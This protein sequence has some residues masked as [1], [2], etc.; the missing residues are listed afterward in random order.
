MCGAVPIY[1]G[2]GHQYAPHPDTHSSTHSALFSLS[3][4]VRP[5]SMFLSSPHDS[6]SRRVTGPRVSVT[7]AS[8]A[9][10]QDEERLYSCYKETIAATTLH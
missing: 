4:S 10:T 5:R 6:A 9:S 8:A 7:E 3:I 1:D 2:R